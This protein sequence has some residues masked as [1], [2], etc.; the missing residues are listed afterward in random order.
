MATNSRF[1]TRR[2]CPLNP[3]NPLSMNTSPENHPALTLFREDPL[4]FATQGT[5]TTTWRTYRGRRLGPYYRLTWRED[6][7]QRAIYLGRQSPLVDEVRRLLHDG[8]T[9][10]RMLREHRRRQALL[11]EYVIRPIQRYLQEMFCLFGDGLY[12]E[13]W[14]LR[15]VET[16]GPRLTT[17]DV[18]E[19]P[20]SL[21]LP[22]SEGLT[23]E[24]RICRAAARMACALKTQ[25]SMIP[26]F[27]VPPSH[28]L[29]EF[30]GMTE[31]T[32]DTPT[33]GTADSSAAHSPSSETT[34]EN[35][36]CR[37]SDE[38]IPKP[39]QPHPPARLQK[40]PRKNVDQEPTRTASNPPVHLIPQIAK[41]F[42]VSR[43]QQE[44]A[45]SIRAAARTGRRP[46]RPGRASDKRIP[47]APQSHTLAHLQKRPRKNVDQK[48]PHIAR[49]PPG[50]VAVT[51]RRDARQSTKAAN[52]PPC[53]T[54][55]SLAVPPEQMRN[56]ASS[57]RSVHL[58]L[59]LTDQ[60]RQWRYG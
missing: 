6:G 58:E 22:M 35:R 48:S 42:P 50:K 46:C 53:A 56:H 5:V 4:R 2:F 52:P 31:S 60:A 36:P 19:H 8:Q 11:R 28:I 10:R 55:Y 27:P 51:L 23:T 47:N 1:L 21:A 39:S 25:T 30:Y 17:A 16:A 26:E 7:R 18:P 34:S 45:I 3:D 49:G 37:A 44:Q 29:A 14:H 15:G 40:R 59:Q 32:N 20:S 41:S 9:I 33:G 54:A 12:L 43:D 13:G 57:I 24:A 38:R